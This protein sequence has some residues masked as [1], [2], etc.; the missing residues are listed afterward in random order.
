MSTNKYKYKKSLFWLTKVQLTQ[1]GKSNGFRSLRHSN[2][3]LFLTL[4]IQQIVKKSKHSK[5]EG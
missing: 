3:C 4:V 5:S 1:I 2:N